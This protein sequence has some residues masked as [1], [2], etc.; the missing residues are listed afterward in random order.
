[1]DVTLPDGM[2]AAAVTA[3][4]GAFVWA[5]RTITTRHLATLDTVLN[6]QNEI[7]NAQDKIMSGQTEIL[8]K[9]EQVDANAEA[10]K[11]LALKAIDDMVRQHLEV[12]RRLQAIEEGLQRRGSKGRGDERIP[13]SRPRPD[14]TG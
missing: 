5:I 6:T 12:D 2:F 11:N 9:F 4:T 14:H 3:I 10:R 8:Q 7:L 13:P 1:M